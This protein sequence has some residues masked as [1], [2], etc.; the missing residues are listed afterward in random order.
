MNLKSLFSWSRPKAKPEPERKHSIK[1]EH[2]RETPDGG[3]VLP[4][5]LVFDPAEF[6]QFRR[7]HPEYCQ[8]EK[9]DITVKQ[10]NVGGVGVVGISL[11]GAPDPGPPQSLIDE[12]SKKD[13]E[14]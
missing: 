8:P 2:L 13:G 1:T 5:G 9:R 6:S 7:D 12:L 11:H 10:H 3:F 14:S 4:G